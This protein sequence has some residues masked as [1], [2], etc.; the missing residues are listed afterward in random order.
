[1][2]LTKYKI[3]K[4]KP[5]VFNDRLELEYTD[6]NEFL[7]LFTKDKRCVSVISDKEM[8]KGEEKLT[9]KNALDAFNK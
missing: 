6:G 5:A 8:S 2:K 7:Y 9:T 1:M 4:S 3:D